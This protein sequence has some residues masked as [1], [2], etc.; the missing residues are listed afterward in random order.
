M[1]CP[2]KAPSLFESPWVVSIVF[3][4]ARSTCWLFLAG[5]LLGWYQPRVSTLQFCGGLHRT[6]WRWAPSRLPHRRG[7][8]L[9]HRTFRSC[10]PSW[11]FSLDVQ[12]RSAC[13]SGKMKGR[14]AGLVVVTAVWP[15]EF[16]ETTVRVAVY[17]DRTEKLG[18][19][20]TTAIEECSVLA[21]DHVA[22][23]GDRWLLIFLRVS[24]HGGVQAL[25]GRWFVSFPSL[26]RNIGILL[27]MAIE[28]SHFNQFFV[29]MH[30]LPL[31]R[32][33]S[34]KNPYGVVLWASLS[35]T[36]KVRKF[37]GR[38][39][40][41]IGTWS[42]R[43]FKLFRHSILE[44]PCDTL[45]CWN[46]NVIKVVNNRS[47]KISGSCTR[48]LNHCN[49][50]RQS[51]PKLRLNI[52]SNILESWVEKNDRG[53]G[54]KIVQPKDAMRG[55][56]RWMQQQSESRSKYIKVQQGGAWLYGLEA[57]F[58]TVSFVATQT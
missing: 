4:W 56:E 52:W 41:I 46:P 42:V 48:K 27:F 10:R 22:A 6:R 1:Y 31:S 35:R 24:F 5:S 30:T 39:D 37:S 8:S 17:F 51:T 28:S 25:G 32:V 26:C 38:H 50:C 15:F 49:W 57:T 47:D 23:V 45:H 7:E 33:V 3:S 11:L 44:S 58:A 19:F 13:A 16:H 53:T 43:T 55:S 40:G 12:H 20:H 14:L 34:D 54:H 9:I 21:S 2:P 18:D 36:A 29:L